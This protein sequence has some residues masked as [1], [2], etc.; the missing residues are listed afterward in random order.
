MQTCGFMCDLVES[1]E[2]VLV[3]MCLI[4]VFNQNLCFVLCFFGEFQFVI[5]VATDFMIGTP[6]CCSKT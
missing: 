1:L 4:G 5:S 2:R 3:G 6:V